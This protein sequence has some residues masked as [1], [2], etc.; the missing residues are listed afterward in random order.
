M[1]NNKDN[2]RRTTFLNLNVL[3]GTRLNPMVFWISRDQH[4]KG[5]VPLAFVK[6]EK[7]FLFERNG[8]NSI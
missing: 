7:L 5:K 1:R 8:F 6:T 3:S 2:E 4:M